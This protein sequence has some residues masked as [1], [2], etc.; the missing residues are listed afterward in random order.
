[1][2]ITH[3]LEK[4]AVFI[5]GVSFLIAMLVLA[6]LIPNPTQTQFFVFRLVLALSA[7]GVGAFLPGVIRI[8]IPLP[9]RGVVRAGGALALFASVWFV[10]PANFAIE[11][12]APPPK[13]RAALLVNEFLRRTDAGEH[14]SAYDLYSKQSKER[15][16]KAEYVSMG[17]TVRDPLGS[18]AIKRLLVFAGTPNELQGVR[19]PF[20]VYNYQTKFANSEAVWIESAATV[21]EDGVW[22]LFGYSLTECKLPMCQPL[23]V[24]AKASQ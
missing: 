14:A 8:D 5:F 10:N 7:A 6:I 12:I 13:D 20:V 24:F 9:I 22:R 11:G 19:A 17:K 4:A 21:A 23:P 2:P 16:T 3:S 1:M 18:P 15:V